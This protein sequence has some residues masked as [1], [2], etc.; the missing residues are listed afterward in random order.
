MRGGDKYAL[1]RQP[2]GAAAHGI[3]VRVGLPLDLI[4][5]DFSTPEVIT[6]WEA[7]VTLVQFPVLVYAAYKVDITSNATGRVRGQTLTYHMD[8]YVLLAVGDH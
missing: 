1:H 7:V 4:I 5:I 6:L 2:E 8:G 3:G